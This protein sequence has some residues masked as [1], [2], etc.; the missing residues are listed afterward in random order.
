MRGTFALCGLAWLAAVFVA[1]P[2]W[3]RP[4][5]DCVTMLDGPLCPPPL[6][7]IAADMGGQM[8]CGPGQCARD[9]TGAVKCS[10]LPGG[11]A[12]VDMSGDVLCVGGCVTG[13]RRRCVVPT[14]FSPA[15]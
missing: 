3:A 14:K 6:G 1:A 11:G 4:V 9:S 7:G 12:V 15:D 5:D 8:V 2:S 13:E 10:A